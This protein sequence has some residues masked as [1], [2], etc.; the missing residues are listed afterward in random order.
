MT[1]QGRTVSYDHSGLWRAQFEDRT[2]VG[3]L[4]EAEA[5]AYES[6]ELDYCEG[7]MGLQPAFCGEHCHECEA[8]CR[9]TYGACHECGDTA[10]TVDL[11][12]KARCMKHS[13]KEAI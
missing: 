13:R 7:C 6:G 2:V 9:K 11:D 10:H 4:T 3:D 12:K 1:W 8:Y 5:K